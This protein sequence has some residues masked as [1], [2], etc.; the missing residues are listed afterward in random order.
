MLT[1]LLTNSNLNVD[2]ALKE[3]SDRCVCVCVCVCL[4]VC[5]CLCVSVSVCL[6]CC[7]FLV[8][9]HP[10]RT[11][12]RPM[13]LRAFGSCKGSAQCLIQEKKSTTCGCAYASVVETQG[14]MYGTRVDSSFLL[15]IAFLDF[16]NWS[17]V[18]RCDFHFALHLSP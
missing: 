13:C 5:L 11:F 7:E 12:A 17:T 2:A 4:C 9:E 10:C 18:A 3:F 6:W 1:D 8:V 16:P 15:R 14:L